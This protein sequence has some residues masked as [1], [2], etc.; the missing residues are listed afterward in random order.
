MFAKSTSAAAPRRTRHLRSATTVPFRCSG[1]DLLRKV[2][3]VSLQVLDRPKF[4][5]FAS[6]QCAYTDA[7]R[8]P[9]GLQLAAI[10]RLALFDQP[11]PVTQH[12][13]G[14]LVPAGLYETVDEFLL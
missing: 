5:E 8:C 2:I 3:Q 4:L 1:D 13:A 11:Q 14:V 7:S 6:I 9:Q 12:F 10:L